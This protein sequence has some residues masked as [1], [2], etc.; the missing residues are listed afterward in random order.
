MWSS[1]LARTSVTRPLAHAQLVVLGLILVE[2]TPRPVYG[3]QWIDGVADEP[4]F[5]NRKK[6]LEDEEKARVI[7]KYFDGLPVRIAFLGTEARVMYM[8]R[9]P[10]AIE[11]DTGLT[12]GTI[13]HQKLKKRGR[14]GHEKRADLQYLIGQRR[15]HFAIAPLADEEL[16][17]DIDLSGMLDDILLILT[18]KMFAEKTHVV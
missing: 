10:V 6:V 16:K 4:S 15:A 18:V 5:Y 14:I 1:A 17:L 3:E 13:S 12:D 8:A 7:A 2:F 11:S 9:I